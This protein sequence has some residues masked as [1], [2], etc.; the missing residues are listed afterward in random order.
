MIF[1]L[2][3]FLCISYGLENIYI[4]TVSYIGEAGCW[5]PYIAYRILHNVIIDD[6]LNQDA[7]SSIRNAKSRNDQ[8][9]PEN[10]WWSSPAQSFLVSGPIG[11]LDHIFVL[12]RFLCVL[13][14]G[15]LFDEKRGL[16]TTCHSPQT[17]D[18]LYWPSLSRAHLSIEVLLKQYVISTTADVG[19]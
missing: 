3:L 2:S 12:Y 13:K 18:W 19:G 11:S 1:M 4:P 14:Q 9:S 7:L 6:L 5:D 16:T 8:S 10:C 15:P 17:G